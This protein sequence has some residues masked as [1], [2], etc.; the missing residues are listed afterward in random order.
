MSVELATAYVNIQAS[1]KGLGKDITSTMGGAGTDG[2]QVAA[3]GFRQKF[4][5][6]LKGI[7][8]VAGP[9]LGLGLGVKAFDWI[10]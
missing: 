3:Q 8:K 6:G 9:L 1:T 4:T 5:G 7:G 2:G 10:K